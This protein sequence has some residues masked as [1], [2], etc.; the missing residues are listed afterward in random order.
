MVLFSV[1]ILFIIVFSILIVPGIVGIFV[2]LYATYLIIKGNKKDCIK[3]LKIGL[4]LLLIGTFAF[5]TFKFDVK[6][7]L[8]YFNNKFIEEEYEITI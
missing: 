3:S 5:I 2:I 4:I 1:L 8:G 7:E 6:F